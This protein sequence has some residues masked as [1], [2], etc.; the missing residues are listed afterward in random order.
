MRDDGAVFDFPVAVEEFAAV[1]QVCFFKGECL[2][3]I[4]SSHLTV[5]WV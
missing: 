1:S 2:Q 3:L 4:C 5:D